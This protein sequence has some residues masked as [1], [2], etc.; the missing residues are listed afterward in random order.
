MYYNQYP[1][2]IFNPALFQ[3]IEQQ[4]Y[5]QEQQQQILKMRKAIKD[6]IEAARQV[7]P[8]YQQEAI[9]Q[10]LEEILLQAI[11]NSK[12]LSSSPHTFTKHH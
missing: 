2:N 9:N 4:N 10:C 1:Y 12:Q 3:Q 7:A 11:N 6:Y 5:H 8:E